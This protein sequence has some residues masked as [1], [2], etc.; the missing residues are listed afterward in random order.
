MQFKFIFFKKNSS[1]RNKVTK[2]IKKP[3]KS[4]NSNEEFLVLKKGCTKNLEAKNKKKL[5]RAPGHGTRQRG[6]LSSA[7]NKALD[8][9]VFRFF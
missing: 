8:K 5:C 3:K 9:E 4:A 1:K 2:Y 6:S 7:K